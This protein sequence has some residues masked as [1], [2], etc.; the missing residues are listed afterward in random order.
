MNTFTKT[1]ALGRLTR[2]PETRHLPS[3]KSVS[4]FS[5]AFDK[6]VNQE[7]KGYFIDCK[8]WEK[9][10][11]VVSQYLHRGDPVL[12]EGRLDVEEWTDKTTN[13]KRTKVVIIAERITLLGSKSET[14]APSQPR[15][16]PSKPA[17]GAGYGDED[18]TDDD[19][20]F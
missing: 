18:V 10:S 19:L 6:L 1:F 2:D 5:L 15:S 4:E 9:L 14:S 3:G 8:A 17:S 7:K 13:Q 12:V 11:D 20:P 16:Q